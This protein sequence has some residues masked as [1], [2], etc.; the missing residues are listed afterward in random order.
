MLILL[1]F[2]VIA[3]LVLKYLQINHN[4]PN[5]KPADSRRG[6]SNSKP[7]DPSSPSQKAY[8]NSNA[9][10]RMSFQLNVL[11]DS[12][13]SFYNLND[14]SFINRFELV[15]QLDVFEF[16]N[17]ATN[18]R[19]RIRITFNPDQPDVIAIFS[20]EHSDLPII[21]QVKLNKNTQFMS[22]STTNNRILILSI[23][24]EYD[25]LIETASS[26]ERQVFINFLETFDIPRK[27]QTTHEIFNEA[28]TVDDRSKALVEFFK[29]SFGKLLK[30]ENQKSQKNRP[31]S[32]VKKFLDWVWVKFQKIKEKLEN[33]PI[34]KRGQIILKRVDSWPTKQKRRFSNGFSKVHQSRVETCQITKYE[35]AEN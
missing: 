10:H 3:S 18:K 33:L 24:Q 9:Q 7:R 1:S 8:G 11:N 35:L 27:Y 13:A 20:A 28:F 25:L 2:P 19:R 15:G 22:L 6:S 30:K 14:A 32:V 26:I 29:D 12:M 5:T 16:E 21:R 23:P 31:K 17:V 4:K 34:L